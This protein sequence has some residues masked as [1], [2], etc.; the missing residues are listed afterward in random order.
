[1]YY[2]L[3]VLNQVIKRVILALSLRE[4]RCYF[5]CYNS[6]ISLKDIN[7]RIY[8]FIDYFQIYFDLLDGQLPVKIASIS[9]TK[10]FNQP[11]YCI[12]TAN[13]TPEKLNHL[14]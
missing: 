14:L 6:K 5:L 9:V 12:Q 10:S 4:K 8:D 13:K 2:F 11:I 3:S 7:Y 1:M